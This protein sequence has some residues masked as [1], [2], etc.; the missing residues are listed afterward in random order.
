MSP[1]VYGRK[2]TL[3]AKGA[4]RYFATP[5]RKKMGT[6]TIQIHDR[7]DERRCGDFACSVADRF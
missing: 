5:E 6:K 2:L 7:G 1:P 3:S 4:N